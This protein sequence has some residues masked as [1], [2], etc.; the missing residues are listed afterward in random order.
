MGVDGGALA[1]YIEAIVAICSNWSLE[2]ATAAMARGGFPHPVV[3]EQGETVGIL[4]VRDV[5]RCW[6]KDGA[7]CPGPAGA[8]A[9]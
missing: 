2:R 5:V 8:A 7:I 9:G 1:H 3:V 6:T 4:S